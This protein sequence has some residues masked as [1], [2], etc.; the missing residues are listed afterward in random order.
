MFLFRNLVEMIN[1]KP[2]Q[3]LFE[4]NPTNVCRRQ[5]IFYRFQE[6]AYNDEGFIQ[7]KLLV[8]N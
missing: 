7:L 6:L 3:K 4:L 2:A 5:V 1:Y 8:E